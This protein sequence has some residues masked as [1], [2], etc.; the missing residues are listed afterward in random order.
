[1]AGSR[2]GGNDA[3]HVGTTVPES[4]MQDYDED[5]QGYSKY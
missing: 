5:R 1:M 2:V 4:H 3:Y